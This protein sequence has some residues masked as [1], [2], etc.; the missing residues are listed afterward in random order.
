MFQETFCKYLK[1]DLGSLS[2]FIPLDQ[3]ADV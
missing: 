1:P 3:M 2:E